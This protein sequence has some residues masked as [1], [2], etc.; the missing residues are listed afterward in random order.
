MRSSSGQSGDG[1][2]DGAS[3]DCESEPGIPLKR[4]QRRH[5]TTFTAQQMDELEKA[6]DRTQ[7]PD[8]YTREELAQRTKL[9]EARIQVWFS[10]RRA[11]LRK[12]MSTS[13]ASST[14]GASPPYAGSTS[15]GSM[16]SNTSMSPTS[17][18][19]MAGSTPVPSVPTGMT[20]PSA[21]AS[22]HPHDTLHHSMTQT[23]T[24]S[25]TDITSVQQQQQH[26]QLY[27][28]PP[29]FG[30][31]APT[32][33][34]TLPTNPYASL[35]SH[36][37]MANTMMNYAYTPQE[38]SWLQH[39]Q[40]VHQPQIQQQSSGMMIPST[41][42]PSSASV[43]GSA[44]SVTSSSPNRHSTMAHSHATTMAA[45]HHAAFTSMYGWY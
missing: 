21:A 38:S 9:T 34:P 32:S 23:L 19:T 33:S 11:R 10:N 31:T 18:M 35:T 37:Q 15:L 41:G 1:M 17:M 29:N 44:F 40:Q 3:S 20:L 24:S 36:H 39:T 12:Q 6:F 8:V 22:Y 25:T 30:A 14:T 43:P 7:Y 16:T 45:H 26:Q 4:K 27:S 28:V 13:S 2:D 42:S 5:R